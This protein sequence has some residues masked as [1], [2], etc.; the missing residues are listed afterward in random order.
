M[1]LALLCFDPLTDVKLGF[2]YRLFRIAADIP[3]G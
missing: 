1:H 3:D 2:I